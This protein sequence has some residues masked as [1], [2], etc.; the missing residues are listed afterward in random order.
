MGTMGIVAMQQENTLK[1]IQLSDT[2][3]LTQHINAV[4]MGKEKIKKKKANYIG[5]ELR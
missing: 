1:R 4:C 2:Y 5:Y 3:R